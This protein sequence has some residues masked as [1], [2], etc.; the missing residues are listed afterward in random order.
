MTTVHKENVELSRWERLSPKWRRL[1]TFG[2]V[3]LVMQLGWD[4][5]E[6]RARRES[7]FWDGISHPGESFAQE[8]HAAVYAHEKYGVRMRLDGVWTL[9]PLRSDDDVFFHLHSDVEDVNVSMS[10]SPA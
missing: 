3:L 5:W 9:R 7:P 8:A 6:Y 4:A 2:S 1:L 10:A